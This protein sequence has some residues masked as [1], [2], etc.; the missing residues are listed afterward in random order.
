MVAGALTPGGGCNSLATGWLCA[1]PG[2]GELPTTDANN[3]IADDINEAV[4]SVRIRAPLLVDIYEYPLIANL[5]D[6]WRTQARIYTRRHFVSNYC[7]T[8]YI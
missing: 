2:R 3:T 7:V 8:A 5:G 4:L 1:T 6:F